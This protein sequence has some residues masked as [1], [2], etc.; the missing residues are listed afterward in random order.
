MICPRCGKEMEHVDDEPD[1]N[2]SGGWLCVDEK[3][4]EFIPDWEVDN[5]PDIRE[6]G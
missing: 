5:E 1:V 6:V 3:C 4:D 2:V